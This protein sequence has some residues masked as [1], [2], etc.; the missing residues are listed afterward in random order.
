MQDIVHNIILCFLY[1]ICYCETAW[2]A[3][4][5]STEVVTVHSAITAE[6][7]LFSICTVR[8]MHSNTAHDHCMLVACE[9]GM[10][11]E[12][13]YCRST[14]FCCNFIFAIFAVGL[15]LKSKK[16]YSNKLDT[17]ISSV[18]QDIVATMNI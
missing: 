2:L 3:V 13:I 15:G 18:V 4:T 17:Q 16:F 6:S 1:T 14:N 10:Y 8:T 5:W 11:I 7:A 9:I 12:T